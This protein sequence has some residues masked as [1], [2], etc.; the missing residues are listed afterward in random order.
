MKTSL[1]KLL[2]ILLASVLFCPACEKNEI[3]P[4]EEIIDPPSWERHS[5]IEL[6]RRLL[7]QGFAANDAIYLLSHNYFLKLDESGLLEE[8]FISEAGNLSLFN[9]PM[10]NDRLFAIGLGLFNPKKIDI[11]S[12]DNPSTSASIDFLAIDSSFQKINHLSGNSMCVNDN[13]LLFSV[14]KKQIPG[15]S[16][17]NIYFWLFDY[18]LENDHLTL[19]FEKEIKIK[20]PGSGIIYGEKKL[21]EIQV[22]ENEFYCSISNPAVTYRI[23]P[24]GSYKE[25]FPMRDAKIFSQH[26]TLFALGHLGDCNIGYAIKP[27]QSNEWESFSLGVND[28]C[29]S[30]FYQINDRFI[31]LINNQ[32]WELTIDHSITGFDIKE[33]DNNGLQ[34]T[35]IRSMLS[36]KDKVYLA[37]H[38]GL[39]FKNQADFSNYKEE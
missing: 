22:F 28:G 1:S 26:D 3:L 38:D 36:F 29:W 39:F 14:D 34:P 32:F 11:F 24:Q 7:I 23:T 13:K 12:T 8:H 4:T 35:S 16:D 2:F 30:H 27:P 15:I 19:S 5:E 25:L 10:L 9:Y 6:D 21:T 33:M 20:I 18:T 17:P 31:I 37:T